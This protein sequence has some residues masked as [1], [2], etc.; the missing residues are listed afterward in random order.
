MA[1]AD[2][3]SAQLDAYLKRIGCPRR[4]SAL[5][6]TPT[7]VALVMRCHFTAVP[8]ENLD[9]MLGRPYEL[10]ETAGFCPEGRARGF[11]GIRPQFSK[12]VEALRGG[13][14]FEHNALLCWLLCEL[15]LDARL[16]PSQ[17]NRGEGWLPATHTV[18]IVRSWQ[19]RDWVA[20][21][22]FSGFSVPQPLPLPPS[23]AAA[24]EAVDIDA[25]AERRRVRLV[26]LADGALAYEFWCRSA[27][28]AFSGH[29]KVG[30]FPR[31]ARFVRFEP[32]RAWSAEEFRAALQRV[33][34]PAHDN[35]FTNYAV[36]VINRCDRRVSLLNETLSVVEFAGDE[37]VDTPLADGDGEWHAVLQREF[38]IV[39]PPREVVHLPSRADRRRRRRALGAG[40]LIA[41]ALAG[42]AHAL[43]PTQ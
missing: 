24:G 9:I 19:G 13:F 22:G 11:E 37:R 30:P 26:R 38:G 29:A 14:C 33:H 10:G 43:G 23:D 3:R 27:N 21:I 18:V 20:D 39:L 32:A 4:F 16:V 2:A 35:M 34:T 41:I 8:F 28:Q 40:A 5:A 15:G 42:V 1:A 17:V 36:A 6:A 25:T 31:W 7:D 12:L